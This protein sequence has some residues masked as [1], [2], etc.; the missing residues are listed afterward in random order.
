MNPNAKNTS[1]C[2]K[3]NGAGTL[4]W[5]RVANGVCFWCNGAGTIAVQ[6]EPK[7]P[8]DTRTEAE[9]RANAIAFCVY[10]LDEAAKRDGEWVLDDSYTERCLRHMPADVRARF[11]S[12][13]ERSPNRDAPAKGRGL[14]KR[15]ES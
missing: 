1:T 15:L 3:C 14:A 10:V 2:G 11:F 9:K 13:I 7:R 5:T 6:W 12:A 8:V 4:S